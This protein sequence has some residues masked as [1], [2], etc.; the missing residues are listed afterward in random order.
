[1]RIRWQPLAGFLMLTA[2][3][4]GAAATDEGE[5]GTTAVPQTAPAATSSGGNEPWAIPKPDS[6]APAGGLLAGPRGGPEDAPPTLPFSPGD[7]F[8][9]EEFAD[10]YAAL[11]NRA[12][13]GKVLLRVSE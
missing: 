3:F 7:V 11:I 9:L 4:A 5:A 12:A 13:R 10:G 2:M 1:M 6:C 8:A